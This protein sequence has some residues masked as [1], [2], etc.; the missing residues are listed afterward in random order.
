[1]LKFEFHLSITSTALLEY[2]R[3]TAHRVVART[4]RGETV[5]F[6]A[7]LLKPFVTPVGVYGDFVLTCG[8]DFTGAELRRA[9]GH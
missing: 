2:Y 6:P 9:H 8:D 4:H 1:M 3:G 7:S 5:Q